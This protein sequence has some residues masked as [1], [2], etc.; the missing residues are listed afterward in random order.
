M[1]DDPR[2]HLVEQ[3][4]Q[5]HAALDDAF[6]TSRLRPLLETTLTVQQLRALGLVA[7]G[8]ATTTHALA[9][10]LDVSAATVSGVVDR[11]VGAGMVERHA[12]PHDGRVRVLAPTDAGTATLRHLLTLPMDAEL[13]VLAALDVDD[14]AALVRGMW[15]LA[16]AARRCVPQ[17]PPTA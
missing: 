6:L 9:E 1:T 14:L 15:A 3:F 11:L 2:A 8:A 5:A 13:Q 17:A 10:A 12:D 7:T 16:D 4:A